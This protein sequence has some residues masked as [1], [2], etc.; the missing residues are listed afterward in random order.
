MFRTA[1]CGVLVLAFCAF[2]SAQSARVIADKASLRG[3][4][5][6]NGKVVETLSKGAEVELVK[7]SGLW[8]LVQSAEYAGWVFT[9][10]LEVAKTPAIVADTSKSSL[11]T[12]P[13]V[14]TNRTYIRGP[15]G[16]CYYLS[17]SGSKVYVD[18]DLCN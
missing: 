5:A 2:L 3:R 14:T 6:D 12:T 10:D 4:P 16:G 15:R 9:S 11:K 13:A 18:R 17:P 8:Y 7:V 1:A